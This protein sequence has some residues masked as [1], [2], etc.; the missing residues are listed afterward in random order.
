MKT[1]LTLLQHIMDNGALKS[2]RTGTG[3]KSVFGYQMRFNLSD[4]FP[5]LTT[6]KLHLRS[7]IH[8]LLWFIKGDTNVQYL[9]DNKVTIWDEWADEQGNLGPVYGA[10]W[11][12]W[13]GADGKEHDQLADVIGRIKATPYSR[14]HIVS[15]WNVAH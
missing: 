12:R 11:R 15:A 2:D 1:Y 3:T 7:I 13:K 10:Q 4:G 5:C 6:K 8:E 14:R 9:R